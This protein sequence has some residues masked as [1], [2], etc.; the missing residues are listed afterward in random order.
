M[1]TADDSSGAVARIRLYAAAMPAGQVALL[2][3]T[4]CS[5]VPQFL[6]PFFLAN[7]LQLPVTNVIPGITYR[8]LASTNLSAWS[9]IQTSTPPA[10]PTMFTDPKATNYPGRFYRLITP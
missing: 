2:D 9:G 3:R 8:L 10:N 7:V 6:T 5:S 1:R 4:D